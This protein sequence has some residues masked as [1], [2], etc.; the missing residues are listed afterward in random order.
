MVSYVHCGDWTCMHSVKGFPHPGHWHVHHLRFTFFW[1]RT[2]ISTSRYMM[3]S[4]YLTLDPQPLVIWPTTACILLSISPCSPRSA[5]SFLLSFTKGWAF[6]KV[7]HISDTMQHS[8]SS[9][10]LISLSTMPSRSIQA[11]ANGRL[12]LLLA[13]ELYYG[14]LNTHTS[15]SSTHPP[16]HTQVVSTSRP[17]WIMLR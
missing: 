13:A 8:S 17:L 14:P 2:L 7:P 11:A 10:W 6:W 12:S 16:M 5:T 1:V 3:Q 9:V 4:P 15:P